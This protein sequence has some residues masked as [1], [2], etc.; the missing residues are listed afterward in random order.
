MS[1]KTH[2][3]NVMMT[4]GQRDNLAALAKHLDCS[5]GSVV[6]GALSA[7]HYHLIQHIP[8]CAN[9]HRCVAPHLLPPA[10]TTATTQPTH[11]PNPAA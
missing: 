9:G 1:Q 8:V 3:L 5:M 4:P 2:S 7:M 10:P 11:T 6:R